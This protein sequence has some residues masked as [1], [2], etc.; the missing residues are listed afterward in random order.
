LDGRG[1]G[2]GI[3]RRLQRAGEVVLD[4]AQNRQ[5]NGADAPV[6]LYLLV[7]LAALGVGIGDR[8]PFVALVDFRHLGVEPD[9]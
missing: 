2:H 4:L 1:I 9:Q 6:G 3:D 5:R 8:D 7:G